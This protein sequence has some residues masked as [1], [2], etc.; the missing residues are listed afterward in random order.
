LLAR[1]GVDLE[2]PVVGLALTGMRP[3]LARAA[4]A[5]IVAAMGA[6]PDVEF[7]FIPMSRH[8]SVPAHDDLGFALELQGEHPRLRVVDEFAHP[9]VIL[10][11]FSAFA[12]VV[13]MRYHGML[14]ADRV[15]V[16][17]VPIAY[18]EKNLRWLADRGREAVPAR[19]EAVIGALRNALGLADADS[20]GRVRVAS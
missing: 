9:A 16:P 17:L 1:A 13:S 18:A 19:S 8:P 11:A 4:G 15:G 10:S 6:M 5:A 14:F 3:E 12:S 7:C 20:V 2:R